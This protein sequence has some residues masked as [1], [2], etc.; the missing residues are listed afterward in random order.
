MEALMTIQKSP[1]K[2]VKYMF[3]PKVASALKVG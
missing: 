3:N 2:I 1:W